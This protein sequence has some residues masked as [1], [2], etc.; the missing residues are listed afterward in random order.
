MASEDIRTPEEIAIE[1]RL[2]EIS[3]KVFSGDYSLQDN[4]E[5]LRFLLS[6]ADPGNYRIREDGRLDADRLTYKALGILSVGLGHFEELK[7]SGVIDEWSD[8]VSPK[9]PEGIPPVE[10]TTYLWNPYVFRDF[11]VWLEEKGYIDSK[12]PQ[13]PHESEASGSFPTAT[14]ASGPRVGRGDESMVEPDEV[15]GASPGFEA[16]R[17]H[18][19]QVSWLVVV[20]VG[21]LCS[22]V[23]LVRHF[24][25]ARSPVRESEDRSAPK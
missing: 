7:Q 16:D 2:S 25:K 4:Q 18:W 14:E 13:V 11:F 9:T 15:E 20:L 10:P 17:R 8:E 1:K 24:M 19:H 6:F 21:A 5:A 3:R 22:T 23:F 12:P